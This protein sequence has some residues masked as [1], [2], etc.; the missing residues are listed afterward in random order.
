MSYAPARNG[1]A[2]LYR[3]R[4]PIQK[5]QLSVWRSR[6]Q[7]TEKIRQFG[8]T[9]PWAESRPTVGINL[10]ASAFS[11]GFTLSIW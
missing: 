6:V 7:R 3:G 11:V 9:W 5:C 2:C 10:I 4:Q 1:Q 8:C